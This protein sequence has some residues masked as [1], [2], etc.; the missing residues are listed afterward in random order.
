METLFFYFLMVNLALTMFYLIYLLLLKPDT[1]IRVKRF[2]FLVAIVF[3]L[4]YQFITIDSWV[5]VFS[6][7]RNEYAAEVIVEQPTVALLTAESPTETNWWYINRQNIIFCVM[8]AGT[9][10]F[11]VRFIVQFI[12]IFHIK[13]KSILKRI[14]SQNVYHLSDEMLP[15]SFFRWIFINTE[16]HSEEELK[17]ILLH[18]Q[19]HVQ[20]WHSLDIVLAELLCIF[21]WWNPIVWLLKKEIAI[22]LEYLADSEILRKGVNS[23]DYQYN[24]LR[25][26]YHETAVQI[27]NNFNVSQ[28]KQRIMM[29]NKNKSPKQQLAKYLIVLPLFILLLTVN[30]V[31]AQNKEP[32]KTTISPQDTTKKIA[33]T[34]E[35][36]IVVEKAPQFPGGHEALMKYLVENLNYPEQAQKERKQGRV[37]CNFIVEKDGSISNVNIVQGIDPVLDKEAIRCIESMPK[38]IPGEQRGQIVRVRCTLPI[39]FGLPDSKPDE[40][41]PEMILENKDG[42]K[43]SRAINDDEIFMVV[44]NQPEFPGGMPALLNYLSENIRYPEEAKNKGIQGRVICSFVVEKDGSISSP[45]I[46]RGGDPLWDEEAIRVINAMPKWKPGTQR[47]IPV[48]VMFSL[49]IQFSLDAEKGETKNEK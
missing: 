5:N 47:G 13:H 28:L 19:I 3:S 40:T 15:F 33:Q 17:Q 27:V 20:Q 12:T 29:M 25:L 24:L 35:I 31:Y 14:G 10:F 9:V 1:F 42:K 32:A 23:R 38:W 8:A 46:K 22:N 36:F 30:S 43:I 26:T 21:F 45:E 34:D 37:I 18:E 4:V 41:N 39:I 44:E 2:Y 16:A 7:M 11:L 48:R 49:P 6:F